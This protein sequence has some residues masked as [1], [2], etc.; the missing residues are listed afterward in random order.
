MTKQKHPYADAPAER[1]WRRAVAA[2][3][4]S[5]V[6]PVVRFSFR[7]QAADRVVSAG[8]CFAQHVSR[9]LR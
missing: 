4:A 1:V 7:I 2:P 9:K 6:D 5:E 3:S 8:S